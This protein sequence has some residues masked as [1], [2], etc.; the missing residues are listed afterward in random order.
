V[1]SF[2]WYGC[3]KRSIFMMVSILTSSYQVKTRVNLICLPYNELI[4]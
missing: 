4:K 1:V 3:I 2:D